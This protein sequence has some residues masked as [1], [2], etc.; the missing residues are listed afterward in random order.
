[1][2]TNTSFFKVIDT[3][4]KAYWFGFLTADGSIQPSTVTLTLKPSDEPHVRAFGALFGQNKVVD[5]ISTTYISK[6]VR[7]NIHSVELARDLTEKGVLPNKTNNPLLCETFSHV[8]DDLMCHFIRGLIDGDGTISRKIIKG[9][10][11]YRIMFVGSQARFMELFSEQIVK[12]V[13]VRVPA[14]VQPYAGRTTYS[15]EWNSTLEVY[16]IGCWLYD[17]STIFLE[18]KRDIFEECRIYEESRRRQP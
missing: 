18:R 4:E 2:R 13:K 5:H 6:G 7:I 8:P 1:M 15:V 10:W 17:N 14:I 16:R 9:L 11:R 12:G 3:E